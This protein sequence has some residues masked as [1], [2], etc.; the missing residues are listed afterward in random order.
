MNPLFIVATLCTVLNGCGESQKIKDLN[1][2]TEKYN[3]TAQAIEKNL[4]Q[5]GQP[6][7]IKLYGGILDSKNNLKPNIAVIQKTGVSTDGSFPLIEGSHRKILEIENDPKSND[8]L[9]L[10]DLNGLK[11]VL[12]FGCPIAFAAKYDSTLAKD[13]KNQDSIVHDETQLHRELGS[14]FLVAK[15]KTILICETPKFPE[16]SYIQLSAETI[17]LNSAKIEIDPLRQNIFSLKALHLELI[18]ENKI[19]TIPNESWVNAGSMNDK[20]LAY[21]SNIIEIIADDIS[22]TGTLTLQ[23]TGL[24]ITKNIK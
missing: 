19:E 9:N 11:P 14:E 15:A 13:N 16:G 2:Q 3:Q 4:G 8:N 24:N 7:I 1:E 10:Q 22:E 6:G 12:N 18:S 17:I 5:G 21:S 23:Q 20:D